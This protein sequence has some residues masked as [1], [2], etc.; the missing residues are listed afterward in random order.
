[1]LQYL[2]PFVT[3]GSSIPALNKVSTNVLFAAIALSIPCWD[4]TLIPSPYRVSLAEVV[5][6]LLG[7]V[8]A[9]VGVGD[10]I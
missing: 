2:S 8:D 3:V 4:I 6:S 7:A 1:M 5:V 9:A 10:M